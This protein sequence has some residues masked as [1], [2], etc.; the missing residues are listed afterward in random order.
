ML[1]CICAHTWVRR[2]QVGSS[3]DHITFHPSDCISIRLSI[4]P[5][6][7][8]PTCPSHCLSVFLSVSLSLYLVVHISFFCHYSHGLK[9][10]QRMRPQT[11]ESNPL[12]GSIMCPPVFLS[13]HPSFHMSV[14]LYVVILWF[15]YLYQF[16][17]WG[18][19]G[20]IHLCP[21]WVPKYPSG[22]QL[23]IY[24]LTFFY[25]YIYLSVP[26]SHFLAKLCA[27]HNWAQHM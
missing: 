17:V 13:V 3:I 7:R 23:S 27:D 19:S 11:T 15:L 12:S 20:T 2:T 25:C 14:W 22:V 8:P 18:S 6:V 24:I 4:R 1:R 21:N 26:A 10:A 16:P 9:F 5:S